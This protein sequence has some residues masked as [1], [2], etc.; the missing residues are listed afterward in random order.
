MSEE[1]SESYWASIRQFEIEEFYTSGQPVYV[2]LYINRHEQ[3]PF[4]EQAI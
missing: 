4:K 3:D 1:G 2:F